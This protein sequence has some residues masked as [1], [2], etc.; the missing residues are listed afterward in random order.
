MNKERTMFVN[1]LMHRCAATTILLF[2]LCAVA[3]GLNFSAVMTETVKGETH[4]GVI[5]V[6]D[7]RY[8]IEGI[9]SIEDERALVVIVDERIHLTWVLLPNTKQYM[10]MQIS[11]PRSLV[12]DPFQAVKHAA[13]LGEHRLVG[14]TK[15]GGYDCEHYKI[16]V[17]D[18]EVMDEWVS[19]TLNFPIK[20]VS[21]GPEARTVELTSFLNRQLDDSLFMIPAG[22]VKVGG[23]Q[24]EQAATYTWNAEVAHSILRKPPFQRLMFSEEVLRM[25]VRSD[26]IIR[27]VVKNQTDTPAKF[28][29]VPLLDREPIWDPAR[30]VHTIERAGQRTTLLFEETE[31]EAQDI[32]VH[33]AQ[34]TFVVEASYIPTGPRKHV[35]AGETMRVTIDPDKDISLRLVNLSEERSQCWVTFYQNEQELDTNTIGPIDFRTFELERENQSMYR[36]WSSSLQADEILIHVDQGELLVGV[37]Q[38]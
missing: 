15:I 4:T 23:Q 36:V 16:L 1:H 7:G 24:G 20:I 22:Y 14:T 17:E 29:A 28:V 33:A 26:Q 30:H 8:R 13:A 10:E 5:Y 34:G 3:V 12:N 25:P 37:R 9:E 32:A 2:L 18:K 38:P 27:I 31:R 21:A 6:K 19:I 35:S 11:D